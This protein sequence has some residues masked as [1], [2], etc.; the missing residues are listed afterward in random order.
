MLA[1]RTRSQTLSNSQP[2]DSTSED[3]FLSSQSQSNSDVITSSSL[4]SDSGMADTDPTASMADPI[5]LQTAAAT[6]HI[7]CP[8][9]VADNPAVSA[10][11][12][13]TSEEQAMAVTAG[14]P[15]VAARS[16]VHVLPCAIHYNGPAAVQRYFQPSQGIN[17]TI[18][19]TAAATTSAST[20]RPATS[21]NPSTYISVSA[22]PT[23]PADSDT[24]S[25]QLAESRWYRAAFRGRELT[26]EKVPLPPHTIGV[27]L[28]D[29][30][31]TSS[32]TGSSSSSKRHRAVRQRSR[33]AAGDEECVEVEDGISGSTAAVGGGVED[34]SGS[35]IDWVVDGWF[36]SLTLWG[37]DSDW[38][39][40]DQSTVKRSLLD[41]PAIAAALHGTDIDTDIPLDER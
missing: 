32:V 9:T 35:R 7:H 1:R 33:V 16:A 13:L 6:I 38:T 11:I 3:D 40:S 4:D 21:T 31:A 19:A 25:A 22:P 14:W 10:A 8:T 15:E 41:W 17:P 12:D 5:A 18:A 34:E 27:V 30:V 20:A 2:A 23:Q 24:Q 39:G 28:R 26:G 36:D 37:R 29:S